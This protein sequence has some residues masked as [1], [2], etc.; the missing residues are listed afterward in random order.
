[1]ENVSN[2][3]EASLAIPEARDGFFGYL[4]EKSLQQIEEKY[5]AQRRTSDA[6]SDGSLAK[7]TPMQ[8]MEQPTLTGSALEVEEEPVPDVHLTNEFAALFHSFQRCLDLRDKYMAKSLQRLGDNPKDYDSHTDRGSAHASTS[9]RQFG[10]WDIYPPPPPPHW[11][12]IDPTKGPKSGA[13]PDAKSTEFRFEDCH[14]PGPHSWSFR[15][16]EKGVFQVYNN[17][18]ED[19]NGG[20]KKP[21]FDVPDIREYFVDLDYVL[22]VIADGPTKSFAFR[23]LKYLASKFEMYALLNE[24]Q[25]TADMKDVVIFRDGARLTLAQVFESLKLTAYD[26]SID[27]LDMHA[28]TDAFHR[29]DKFNLKYNPLGESRLREIFLKTDNL[30]EGRYLAELTRRTFAQP[31]MVTKC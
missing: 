12:W 31:A 7:L 6:R 15:I 5:W 19:E 30:I 25:E 28:H 10:K 20:D 17:D 3:P 13:A 14:I 23:R 29:F 16:D 9:T 21:A 11:R 1:M 24:S 22:G 8:P 27:T 2:P 18:E 4:E 26:L